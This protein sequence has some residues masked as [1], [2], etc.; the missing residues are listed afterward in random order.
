MSAE[1]RPVCL[2]QSRPVQDPYSC[3]WSQ[4]RCATGVSREY[5]AYSHTSEDL[6]SRVTLKMPLILVGAGGAG[7]LRLSMGLTSSQQKVL[8]GVG[9]HP[10]KFLDGAKGIF[11]N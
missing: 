2:L 5:T 6:S 8:V 4:C 7:I 10:K 3:S 1:I 9:G 11:Y